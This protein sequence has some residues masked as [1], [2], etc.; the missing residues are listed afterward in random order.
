MTYTLRADSFDEIN[1]RERSALAADV[2]PGAIELLLQSTEGYHDGDIIYVGQP[3]REGCE[4][5]VIASVE[6]GTTINLSTGLEMP[7]AAYEPVASVVGDFIQFERAPNVD[8]QVPSDA[9]FEL[10]VNRE[11][12]PDQTSTYYRD[13]DGGSGYWYRERYYNATTEEA[14][15]YLTRPYRGSDYSHYASLKEIRSEAG[16]DGAVH[17]KDSLIDQQRRAAEAE[18]N[19]ALALG[20]DVPF[21]DVVPAAVKSLTIKLA[22]AMLLVVAYGKEYQSQLDGVRKELRA[23]ADRSASITDDEGNELGTG[24]SVSGW[25]DSEEGRSFTMEMLF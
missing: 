23:Y 16:F 5:A 1:I 12:D 11:I 3:S 8:G 10:L 25:P 24:G 21:K 9:A 20:Y 2:L 6:D 22:A 4:K 15:D 19:A 7:H 17:L 14:T 13:S 18:I